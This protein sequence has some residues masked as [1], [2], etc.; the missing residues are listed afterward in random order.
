MSCSTA[1]SASG[2]SLA[3]A[4]ALELMLDSFTHDA[5]YEITFQVI[6]T[7]NKGEP[8]KGIRYIYFTAVDDSSQS[9]F[10]T[11]G[12]ADTHKCERTRNTLRK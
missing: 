9:N 8:W 1:S 7:H 4:A 12:R 2:S 10:V 6:R 11:T 3:V 5:R